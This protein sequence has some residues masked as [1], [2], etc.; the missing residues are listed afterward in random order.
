MT[1][2][3][4]WIKFKN[5]ELAKTKLLDIKI[6]KQRASCMRPEA[7]LK[8]EVHEVKMPFKLAKMEAKLPRNLVRALF[9]KAS[10]IEEYP[11]NKTPIVVTHL[12]A[13]KSYII[14]RKTKEQKPKRTKELVCYCPALRDYKTAHSQTRKVKAYASV[15]KKAKISLK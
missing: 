8:N 3:Q 14:P 7:E 4:D 11:W 13:K 9:Y 15:P 12:Y 2:S 6:Q 10:P 5:H 1:F